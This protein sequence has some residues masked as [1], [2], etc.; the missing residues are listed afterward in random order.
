MYYY[1]A[2]FIFWLIRW[3]IVGSIPSDIKKC[4]IIVA[5]HTSNYDF[6]LGRI[7]CWQMKIKA[8]YLI[9]QEA[10]KF[11]FGAILKALGGIPVNRSKSST[12]VGH[13]VKHINETEKINIV[14]TPEGT[15]KKVE[16]WKKGYYFFA[17]AANIPIALAFIDYQKKEGGIGPILYPT[18]D[19]DKDYQIIHD[20][21]KDIKGRHPEKFTI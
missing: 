14:V 13:V 11:P 12:M 19:Y 15:R 7:A 16:K 2:K 9:K 6:V 1:F 21:Y 8:S 5:P 10:F 18:G 20:F 4:V 17:M 3:K